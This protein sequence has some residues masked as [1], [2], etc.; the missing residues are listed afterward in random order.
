MTVLLASI[1]TFASFLNGTHPVAGAS[2]PY[3][4]TTAPSDTVETQR[5]S[6]TSQTNQTDE[7]QFPTL[8]YYSYRSGLGLTSP[9]STFRLN[10]RFRMQNRAGYSSRDNQDDAIDGV[11]RR[12]RLRFDGFV[13]DPRFLYAIQLSFA[14]A[15]VGTLNEGDNLNI[16]RDAMFFYRPNDRWNIGFGQ[17]KLPGNRQRVNSSGALQLTDRSINNAQF[18]IDRDYG[19]HVYYLMEN[20]D[21]IGWNLKTA[22]ST[23]EGR[24]WTQNPSTSL[25]YTG[26]VELFPLGAFTD[27]GWNFEGDLKN[28]QTPKLLLGATW[29]LNEGARR[30][31]GQLGDVLYA[32]REITSFFADAMLKYRG[33]SAMWSYMTR[34]S[35]NPVTYD[36]SR[37]FAGPT[38]LEA[39]IAPPSRF[40]YVGDGMDYQLSY[41]LG[42]RNDLVVRHSWQHPHRDIQ[43]R[44]PKRSEYSAG[45]THYVWEHSL[46]LQ[47]EFTWQREE[48]H[49][50]SRIDGWYARFQI[51]IGI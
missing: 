26:R 12:L 19:V 24:N 43:F 34:I 29:H 7:I 30:T 40:V 13:G 49:N 36:N 25:A 4:L 3:L 44:A 46:K 22:I 35:D 33:W 47:G 51:E 23:G 1:L 6:E 50:G 31:R 39:L 42:G 21:R 27:G 15:D 2:S 38:T 10:I 18:T 17:T 48:R 9:D 8:P 5:M 16:I 14:P 41:L 37:T 11:V 28:E 32:P 45:L 20:N